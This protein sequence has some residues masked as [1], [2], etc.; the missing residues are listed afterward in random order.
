MRAV[1]RQ[2]DNPV[3]GIAVLQKLGV[4]EIFNPGPVI[5]DIADF[6]REKVKRM[7]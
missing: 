2:R 4:R 3:E 5:K 7:G 1:N 6:M